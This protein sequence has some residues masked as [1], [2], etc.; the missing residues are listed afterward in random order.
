MNQPSSKPA[1]AFQ[2]APNI[3]LKIPGNVFEATLAF[4]RDTLRLPVVERYLPNHVF[5]FGPSHLWL[6]RV[7]DLSHPEVWLELSTADTTAAKEHLAAQGVARCDEV[8]EL[9]AGFDGFFVRSPPGTV[10]L[11]SGQPGAA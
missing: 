8:E 2:G 5:Q 3:A 6:D 1:P 4:Y 7:D 10:H 11:V 9:P